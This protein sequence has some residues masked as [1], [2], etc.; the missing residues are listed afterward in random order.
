[1]GIEASSPSQKTRAASGSVGAKCVGM[2]VAISW[3]WSDGIP[4]YWVTIRHGITCRNSPTPG[5]A[6][7]MARNTKT[8]K[9]SP[10]RSVTRLRSRPSPES[11]P[12]FAASFASSVPADT[13]RSR[14][15]IEAMGGVLSET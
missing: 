10:R 4:K 15:R 6:A 7:V 3:R 11:A 9:I 12:H 2:V 1:M 5:I 14:H 13:R 8:T